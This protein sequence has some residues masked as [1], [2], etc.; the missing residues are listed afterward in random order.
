MN[1]ITLAVKHA[2]FLKM[3]ATGEAGKYYRVV[4]GIPTDAEFIRVREGEEVGKME[5]LFY[6]PELPELE[7]GDMIPRMEVLFE[8]LEIPVE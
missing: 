7:P 2:D 6:S 1:V 3:F 5:L 4:Q 8:M